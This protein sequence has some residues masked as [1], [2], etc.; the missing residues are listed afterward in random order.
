MLAS[1]S[2]SLLVRTARRSR[3][4]VMIVGALAA[5]GGAGRTRLVL[6]LLRSS[7]RPVGRLV[8]TGGTSGNLVGQ[9][10][11]RP[12]FPIAEQSRNQ[13]TDRKSHHDHCQHRPEPARSRR[14]STA[15]AACRG[16]RTERDLAGPLGILVYRVENAAHEK[17]PSSQVRARLSVGR[18]T[19]P[20]ELFKR[21]WV[22][23][24]AMPSETMC[25][26]S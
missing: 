3:F 10:R 17:S 23:G 22:I 9:K 21:I 1:V 15:S 18:R 26:A 14:V 5:P 8:R 2:L 4:A 11:L 25:L 7:A 16:F 12:A 6:G 13:S 20:S 19:R 24:P